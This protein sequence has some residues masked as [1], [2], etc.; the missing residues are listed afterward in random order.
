MTT[1]SA[2]F[3]RA[4][5]AILCSAF[6]NAYLELHE[7]EPTEHIL[8]LN[9]SHCRDTIRD[10]FS[11]GCCFCLCVAIVVLCMQSLYVIK[12]AYTSTLPMP[13]V[14]GVGPAVLIRSN[15]KVV[16]VRCCITFT[17]NV[18]SVTAGSIGTP[19]RW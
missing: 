4:F 9:A 7:T 8:N 16:I 1:Y 5:A 12:R 6:S 3:F 13:Y 10:T 19:K 17:L 14:R 18:T 2:T 11:Y 15:Y